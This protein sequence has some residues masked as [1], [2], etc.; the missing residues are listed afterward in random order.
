MD[1][2]IFASKFANKNYETTIYSKR[3]HQSDAHV[4]LKY[5]N[6]YIASRSET[7]PNK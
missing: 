5:R 6:K 3:I 2:G 4:I 1:A 7:S